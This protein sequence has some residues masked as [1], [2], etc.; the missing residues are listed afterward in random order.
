MMEGGRGPSL[1]EGFKGL[2]GG[3][4]NARGCAGLASVR[5]GHQVL[6]ES[7]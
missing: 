6:E 2:G 3:R 4:R 5:F 7:F 1:Q